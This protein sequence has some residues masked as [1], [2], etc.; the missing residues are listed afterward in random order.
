MYSLGIENGDLFLP[1]SS[2][3]S[4][5]YAKTA[6]IIQVSRLALRT[7]G[8]GCQS[9]SFSLSLTPNCLEY[10]KQ[11]NDWMQTFTF[12]DLI[13]YFI[14]YKPDKKRDPFFIEI[15]NDT[16]KH[17][18]VICPE[19][20]FATTNITKTFQADNL[21][22]IQQMDINFTL[23]GCR[24]S[25]VSAKDMNLA[26]ADTSILKTK[27]VVDNFELE[28]KDDVS[29]SEFI[30][31]PTSLNLQLILSDSFT[32]KYS[33]DWLQPTEAN[34]SYV[35]VENFGKFY[36]I[37]ATVDDSIVSYECS[38]FD[39]QSEEIIADTI[40]DSTLKDAL[41]KLKTNVDAATALNAINIEHYKLNGS[42][43]DILKEISSNLGCLVGFTDNTAHLFEVPSDNDAQASLA[44]N[45]VLNFYITEDIKSAP[46]CKV[47]YRDAK[48]QYAV[49]DKKGHSIIVESPICTSTDRSDKLLAYYD[50]NERS[51]SMTLPFDNRIRHFLWIQANVDGKL[52]PCLV[53]DYSIDVLDNSMTLTL[54]YFNRN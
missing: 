24:C 26:T 4:F 34:N 49:G 3:S 10:F 35:E 48:H 47:I 27:L 18:N 22:I 54:N 25:K 8:Y 14:E 28:C 39:K 51:I 42:S 31:T 45:N 50:F 13:K 6:N 40:I 30:L 41:N 32:D 15:F 1:L 29:I 12:N 52:I 36:I 20:L 33:N 9:V 38:I 19:L 17:S 2:V 16:S 37:N 53:S 44:D 46:T 21:G 11:L 43:V 23:T 5:S 7:R